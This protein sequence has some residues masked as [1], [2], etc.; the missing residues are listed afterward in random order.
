MA[1]A[2]P[3]SSV[4]VACPVAAGPV[5]WLHATVASAGAVRVGDVESTTTTVDA[6]A[7]HPAEFH[8]V[9]VYVPDFAALTEE[10]VGFWRELV[11]P[12]GPAQEYE[13]PPLETSET[14]APGQ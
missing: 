11:N 10:I 6:C 8:T 12:L 14:V 2:C 1:G 4:A 7:T 13:V 5:G 9:T 3:E